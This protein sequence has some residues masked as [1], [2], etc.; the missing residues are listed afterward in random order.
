MLIESAK[1]SQFPT[2]AE[3]AKQFVIESRRRRDAEAMAFVEQIKEQLKSR[4]MSILSSPRLPVDWFIAECKVE[5][6][7]DDYMQARITKLV[8]EWYQSLDYVE[9]EFS[10]FHKG[11]ECG[12]PHSS[13]KSS[14][15]FCFHLK[16]KQVE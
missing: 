10:G 4:I 5:L 7:P 14:P 12:P 8:K 2:T 15:E 11:V 6:E 3:E 1:M 16:L 9:I 13:Y